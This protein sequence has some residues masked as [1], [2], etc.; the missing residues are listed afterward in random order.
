MAQAAGSI[1]RIF[2]AQFRPDSTNKFVSVGVQHVRFWSLAG[3]KLLSKRGTL[4]VSAS[5]NYK[6]QTMLSIAFAPVS[7][8]LSLSLSLSLVCLYVSLV[9]FLE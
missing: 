7:V 4:N 9:F 8:H 6:M 5:T 1:N 3:S 2:L